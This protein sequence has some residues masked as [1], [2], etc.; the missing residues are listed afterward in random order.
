MWKKIKNCNYEISSDGRVR[1]HKTKKEL[2]LG[3]DS[4]GY[5]RVSF[6]FGSRGNQKTMFIH[7][8]VAENFIKNTHNKKQVNHIDGDKLNNN[9]SNLEWVTSKENI[10]HAISIGLFNVKEMSKK[11]NKAS[12]KHISKPIMMEDTLK[13]KK[14]RY[15]SISDCALKNNFPKSSVNQSVNSKTMYKGRYKFNFL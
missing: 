5:Y 3:K 6:S 13:C 1:N 14:T 10:N 7:R 11:A 9:C 15:I 12:L 8:L 2:K 4:R